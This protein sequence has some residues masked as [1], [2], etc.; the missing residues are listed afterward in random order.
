MLI[1]K[2]INTRE[3][4]I[5]LFSPLFCYASDCYSDSINS[6]KAIYIFF[7]LIMKTGEAKYI[8]SIKIT[9]MGENF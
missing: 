9:Y 3:R 2:R 5:K 7:F 4:T 6:A 8:T 1:S